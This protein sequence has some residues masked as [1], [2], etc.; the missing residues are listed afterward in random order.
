MKEFFSP[1]TV[2]AA[3]CTAERNVYAGIYID[4][5]CGL[6]FCVE[7]AVV[8]EMLKHRAPALRQLW[9]S[10]GA[11]SSAILVVAQPGTRMSLTSFSKNNIT[12]VLAEFGK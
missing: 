1:G 9:L 4:M 11:V 3:I 8:S 7:M 5:A 6:G 12:S 2:A 10:V